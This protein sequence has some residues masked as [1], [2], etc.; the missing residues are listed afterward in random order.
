ML[1][2][3]TVSRAADRAANQRAAA[4]MRQQGFEP[5]AQFGWRGGVL[6]AWRNPLQAAGEAFFV[7]G[8]QG[9]ACCIGPIWYRGRFGKAALHQLLDEIAQPG[10][11]AGARVE[12]A[13]P[14]GAA[15]PAPP[16]IDETEL[17]GNFALFL[18]AGDRAW[19]LND[20]LG[21]ARVY[22]AGEGRYLS[23]SWLAARAWQGSADI[24]EA[25]AIEYV[26]QGAVHSDRT[27]AQG[28]SKLPLG[29]GFDLNAGQ[30]YARFPGG[31]AGA[32]Q[33]GEQSEAGSGMNADAARRAADTRSLDAAVD[34]MAAHLRTV[35]AEIAGA[36]PGHASAALSGGFDSRLIVAGLLAQG[37]RPR[38]FVYGS[39]HSEDVPI[40]RQVAQAEGIPITVVDKDAANR[41]LP[42]P[43]LPALARSA[44]FFDGLPN[45]G[46]FDPGA[47]RDTRLAQ[48]AGGNIALNGG[49]GEIFRNFFHLPDRRYRPRDIVRAFYRGFDSGVFRRADGLADYERGLAGSIAA[50]LG[51][52]AEAGQGGGVPLSREQVEL[53]Y[54]FFRCHHWMGLNNSVALRYG[55][56]ATP[57]VDLRTVRAAA[58]LPLEWK[59]AGL[60]ESRLIAAL[61]PG[62]ASHP[63]SYGFRFSDGPDAR[64]RKTERLTCLRPVFARPL[65]NAARR[66]LHRLAASPDFVARCRAMLPGEWRLDAALDL[67]RLPDDAAFARALS[68][69][70]VSREL[71]P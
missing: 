15:R 20:P 29:R 43:D 32:G 33:R 59:N 63:S 57:L 39:E 66:R 5:A 6:Q 44:L 62:I 18:H 67:A 68:V 55:H 71:A 12:S 41:Q 69:E 22:I 13:A 61:H 19:L 14:G 38:L 3:L 8:P 53:V 70:V 10:Q 42:A 4:S 52:P 48:S 16:P 58:A 28:V 37:E 49:G 7:D 35:F 60:F 1:N 54:P 65:I 45:D 27:V 36:F 56:F 23:T 11:A 21:F 9:T 64:A 17:R 26:L 25:A 31:M 50:S 2:A 34:Q 24:D 40:A 51:L 46:I 47:D 30:P